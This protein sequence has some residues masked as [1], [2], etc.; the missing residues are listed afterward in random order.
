MTYRRID[1]FIA[2][3]TKI[4]DFSDSEISDESSCSWTIG[5]L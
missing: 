2:R 5:N 1:S 4:S 3:N